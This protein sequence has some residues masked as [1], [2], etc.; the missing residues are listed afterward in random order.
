VNKKLDKMNHSELFQF[1]GCMVE[2][3]AF[4]HVRQPEDGPER[5]GR[6]LRHLGH[7]AKNVHLL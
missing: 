7:D 3:A 5:L 2:D 4:A 6:H 1:I